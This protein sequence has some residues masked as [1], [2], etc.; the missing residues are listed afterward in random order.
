MPWILNIVIP[1]RFPRN[2]FI[3]KVT[4]IDFGEIV[5][6]KCNF[7]KAETYYERKFDTKLSLEENMIDQFYSMGGYFSEEQIKTIPKYL[8]DEYPKNRTIS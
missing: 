1:L 2:T 5:F 6:G 4:E 7:C 3:I 8:K